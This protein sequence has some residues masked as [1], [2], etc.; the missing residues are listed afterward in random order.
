VWRHANLQITFDIQHR[1]IITYKTDSPR[2]FTDLQE[3]ITSRIKAILIKEETLDVAAS[4]SPVADVEGLTQ[5]EIVTLVSIAQNADN[6]TDRVSV[7]AIRSDMERAGFTRIATMLGLG[8]LLKKGLIDV[9]SGFDP[10][11]D[12]SYTLYLLT[13]WHEVAA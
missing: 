2:D 7:S 4:I 9:E 8:A 5:H 3:K 11:F 10:E 1:S 12:S 6:P 13:E